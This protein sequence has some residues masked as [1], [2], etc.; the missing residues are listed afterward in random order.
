M[1]FIQKNIFV[2]QS[3]SLCKSGIEMKRRIEVKSKKKIIIHITT[4]ESKC[5][6]K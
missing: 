5:P 3:K 6:F 2:K 4:I 1:I